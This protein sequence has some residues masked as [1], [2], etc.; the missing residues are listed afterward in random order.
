MNDKKIQKRL[1]YKALRISLIL[2]FVPFI[3]LIALNGSVAKNEANE[4]SDIDFWIVT[5]KGRIWTCRAFV[6]ILTQLTGLR[7]DYKNQK[8]AGRACFNCFQTEDNLTIKPQ[9]EKIAKDYSKIFIF[10]YKGDLLNKYLFN[11]KWILNYGQKFDVKI[12]KRKIFGFILNLFITILR[13]IFEFILELF[14]SDWLERKLHDWQEN[15]I[16]KNFRTN[17]WPTKRLYLSNKE[18]RT[19]W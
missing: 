15:K 10:W 2:R 18:I 8:I 5:K 6:L 17:Q 16:K 1:Y 14:F 11:N 3:R 12:L 4:K 13:F 19:H 9:T 7:V